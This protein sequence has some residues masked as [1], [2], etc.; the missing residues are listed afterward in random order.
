MEPLHTP[1]ADDID[2]LMRNAELR[3]RLEPFFDESIRCVNRLEVPTAVENEYLACMLAWEE[4][5][6]LPVKCWFDPPLVLSHPEHLS[7]GQLHQVLWETIHKLFS[8]RI[9]LDFT[10]H[11]SDRELYLLIYRDILPSREKKVDAGDNYLHW[12]CSNV[13][14]DPEVWLRYYATPEERAHWEE[15]GLGY[16]PDHEEPPFKRN[17]PRKPL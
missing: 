10:D 8:K 11:L 6:I 12:D 5:P 17:L 2:V 3:D 1:N 9:V 13:S 7:P 16:A 14:G 15:D 4:A